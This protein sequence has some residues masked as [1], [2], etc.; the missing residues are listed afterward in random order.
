MR[1]ALLLFNCLLIFNYSGIRAWSPASR[2]VLSNW[3]SKRQKII[4]TGNR[5]KSKAPNGSRS[6]VTTPLANDKKASIIE[7]AEQ[8]PSPPIPF[9]DT[10]SFVLAGELPTSSSSTSPAPPLRQSPSSPNPLLSPPR[11]IPDPYGWLRDDSRTNQDVL[12]HLRAENDYGKRMTAHLENLRGE[13]YEEMK[14]N[15]KE[16]DYTT[17]VAKGNYWYYFKMQEGVSYPVYCRA[18]RKAGE[19]FHPPI[20]EDWDEDVATTNQLSPLLEGEEIYLDVPALA[21]DKPYLSVGTI[22]I[23]PNQE[24]LGYTVDLTGGETCQLSVKHISSGKEWVLYDVNG[25]NVGKNIGGKAK[26]TTEVTGREEISNEENEE[27]T[28]TTPL[29]ECDGSVVWNDQNTAVFFVT[30]DEA[31]RPYRVYRRQVFNVDGSYILPEQQKDELLLEEKD[32]LFNMR[33]AKTF[34]GRYL[35]VRSSSKESSEVH[36]LKLQS[37]SE[38]KE[39]NEAI[40]SQ[41]ICIA[42]RRP[43]VLYRATHCQGYWL[44]QTN[45]GGTPNLRLMALPVGNEQNDE[46]WQNVLLK[47]A[48]GNNRP[49]FDGGDKRSLDGVTVFSPDS[50][51]DG[52]KAPDYK[53]MAFGVATGREEGLP[54]IWIMEFDEDDTMT[55]K[56]SPLV[57]TKITRLDFDESA[58]DVGL[59]PNRDPTLPY[60]VVSYDSLVTPPSNIA[61]PLASPVDLNIRRVLKQKVVPGYDK[62]LYACERTFVKS[63][64]GKTDIPVSLVYRQDV[65][66]KRKHGESIPTHLYGY[67]SYGAS[68]EASFR[69][70]RLPLLN[71]G[72]VYVIAHVRGGGENGRPWYEEPMGAKYLCKKNTFNDFVDVA[73]WLTGEEDENQDTLTLARPSIGK[74]IT[75]SRK[76]SCEGRS[77]GGLL[78]GASM[79]QSPELFQVAILGVPFVDVACTMVD[80]TIPL[81][82]AEWEEWGNPNEEK[83]HDFILSYCPMNNVK[84]GARYPS[85]LLT[86]GLYDPR[87]QYWEPAK[88]AAELRHTSSEDSGPIVLKMDM[89]AGHFSASDRYKYLKD[90]AF[91]Y[92][93]LFDQ[94]GIVL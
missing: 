40:E 51:I 30:M 75:S 1:T 73:R 33:I 71:R 56:N 91:D 48:D 27:K 19:M 92:A 18:P 15:I 11:P 22:S 78:I 63:R 82:V 47:S 3:Q 66:E 12:D 93:Y 20:R 8:L 4:N 52:T 39:G 76:L 49:V 38:S 28:T 90:L 42:K 9:R 21:R 59:G 37:G 70:T 65:L 24:Y 29:L 80:A 79:N 6:F 85:C 64:D 54:R 53:P 45:Y 2:I 77:A 88:F 43:K 34:D 46:D 31:H 74:G 36:Y 44:I 25:I 94:L 58:C 35:I 26:E 81:T 50:S 32:E 60:V 57:V 17:P 72:M 10:A 86:G 67:G 23:S 87:V 5:K 41:L 62:D 55:G 61:V 89:E 69:A 83:Y 16:T 13:L 14:S 7:A 68:I 84:Y